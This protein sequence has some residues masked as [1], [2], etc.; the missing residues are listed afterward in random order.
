MSIT[1][2]KATLLGGFHIGQL[3]QSNKHNIAFNKALKSKGSMFLFTS[4]NLGAAA[5]SGGTA[6]I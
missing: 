5:K 1:Q 6:V 3:L 4:F 2:E